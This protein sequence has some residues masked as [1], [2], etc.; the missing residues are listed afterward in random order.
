MKREEL[1]QYT[2]CEIEDIDDARLDA[3]EDGI[4]KMARV[5]IA[6]EVD[7]V[8]DAMAARIK[9]L[10]AVLQKER[11]F[12][13][14]IARCADRDIEKL[15]SENAQLK[16]QVPKWISIEDRLPTNGQYVI[17]AG[18]RSSLYPIDVVCW[19]ETYM[20]KY[21]VHHWMPLPLPLPLPP[22]S[23]FHP[24]KIIKRR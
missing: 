10:E 9:E 17:V 11:D 4:I 15:K 14:H 22:N 19:D 7:K 5:Y 23:E 24:I 6:S 16:A 13:L 12:G 3:S 18:T 20:T 2:S 21:K 1:K 8:M